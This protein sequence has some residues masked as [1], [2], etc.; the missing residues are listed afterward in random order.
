MGDKLEKM[1]KLKG[2]LHPKIYLFTL[3]I[4]EDVPEEVVDDLDPTEDGEA[5]EEAHCAPYQTQ[6]SLSSHL[7]MEY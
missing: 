7:P 2:P 6:L 5:S 3:V 4:W 1:E